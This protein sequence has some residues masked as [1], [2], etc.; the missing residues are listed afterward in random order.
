MSG[1]VV[2]PNP[3]LTVGGDVTTRVAD[4]VLPIPPFVDVTAAVVLVR[5]IGSVPRTFTLNVQEPLMGSAAP[6]KLTEFEPEMAAIA[7]PPHDPVWL[8]GVPTT[9]PDGK[10]SVNPTPARASRLA[11]GFVIVNVRVVVPFRGIG[12]VPNAIVI[13]GGNKTVTLADAVAPVPPSVDVTAVVV[14]FCSPVARP[15]TFTLNEQELLAGMVPPERLTMLEP[16]TALM[17]PA[18]QNP[19]RPLLGVATIKAGGRLSVTAM[20]LID[21]AFGF[22]MVKVR[23]VDPFSGTESVPNVAVMVG[24]TAKYTTAALLVAPGPLSFEKTAL[25]V[26]DTLPV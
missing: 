1:T 18:P 14:V 7:P 25:V 15:V 4:A 19:V 26:F 6:D 23:L 5:L 17:V 16:A 11:A 20:P 22:V 2:A 12:L 3:M 8:A 9:N 10:M 24:G 13:K 21:T